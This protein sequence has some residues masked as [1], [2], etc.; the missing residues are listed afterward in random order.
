MP[1]ARARAVR[2]TSL[3]LSTST[4]SRAAARKRRAIGSF[5]AAFWVRQTKLN[6]SGSR[7][8]NP[9]TVS[10]PTGCDRKR[11]RQQADDQ[12]A[13]RIGRVGEAAAARHAAA[14]RSNRRIAASSSAPVVPSRY[15][16]R[17]AQGPP[18]QHRGGIELDCPPGDRYC[19]ILLTDAGRGVGQVAQDRRM[20][21]VQIKYLLQNRPCLGMSVQSHQHGGVVVLHSADYRDPGY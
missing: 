11:P 17:V 6:C 9:A 19:L 12:R 14:A 7:V 18:R 2:A 15:G 3:R 8:S 21:T 20:R 16:Q 10:Q 5:G 4:H 1:L 13:V